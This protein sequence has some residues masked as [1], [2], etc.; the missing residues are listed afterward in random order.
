MGFMEIN[1]ECTRVDSL[2]IK[3]VAY[4]SPNVNCKFGEY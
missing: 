4:E 3:Q 1:S 2:N